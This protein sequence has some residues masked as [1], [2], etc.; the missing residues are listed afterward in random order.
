MKKYYA[1]KFILAFAMFTSLN[2]ESIKVEEQIAIT[3]PYT[4][5]V[6]VGEN[7]YKHTVERVVNCKGNE[8]TN[9]FGL[10]TIIGGVLGVAVG[11]QFGSGSGNDAAK[12]LGGLT[13][14]HMANQDRNNKLC[15]SYRQVDECDPVYEY[16]TKDIVVGYRN[17]ATYKGQRVCKETKKPLDYLNVTQKIYIY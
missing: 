14:M 12:V 8:D 17:C 10:D 7:C 9:A 15:K 3:K 2:A 13:G 6:K 11:N 1:I 5:K 4:T 16:K